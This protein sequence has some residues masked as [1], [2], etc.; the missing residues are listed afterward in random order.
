MKSASLNHIYRLVWNVITQSW[1]V[2]SEITRAQG[3]RASGKLGA[4][5][6]A[7][8]LASNPYV[9]YAHPTGGVVTSGSG[10]ISQSGNTTTINQNSQTLNLNWNTFNVGRNETVNFIQPNAT[11]LAVNQ[12]LDTNGSRI[13]GNIN[14]NG[15]VWLINPNGVYFGQGAQ[16][17]VGSLLASTLNPQG[18]LTTNG[19]QVFGNGGTGSVINEG[20][21]KAMNGG[22]VAL[23]GN[24]V[25]NT[26]TNQRHS[27]AGRGQS[28]QRHLCR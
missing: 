28:G 13:L 23:I 9:S 20:T 19:T 24:T 7:A 1:I 17:N 12:I 26:G 25:S 8:V 10:T 18:N 14:A 21:I 4:V 3:K 22:Y 16:I 6:S 2:V 27:C 5:V 11:S 15:Q